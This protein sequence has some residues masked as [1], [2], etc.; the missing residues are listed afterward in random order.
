MRTKPTTHIMHTH[1]A[2]AR[3]ETIKRGLTHQTTP[4]TP[5]HTPMGEG[6]GEE[7]H[8]QNARGTDVGRRDRA[9]SASPLWGRP[10]SEISDFK[11][12]ILNFPPYSPPP[13]AS[14]LTQMKRKAVIFHFCWWWW[15]LVVM[16][17]GPF[18]TLFLDPIFGR[19]FGP[20]LGKC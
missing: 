5:T 7:T 20:H 13:A 14:N 6:T 17:A 10:G 9:R 11:F 3:K 8:R 15:L 16:A 19:H 18:W 12:S 1:T 4:T 2:A